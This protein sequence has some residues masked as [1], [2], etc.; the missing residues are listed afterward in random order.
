MGWRLEGD[1][2]A[3]KGEGNPEDKWEMLLPRRDGLWV[4]FAGVSGGTWPC[5]Q[6][7]NK[8]V[9]GERLHSQELQEEPHRPQREKACPGRCASLRCSGVLGKKSGARDLWTNVPSLAPSKK[10]GWRVEC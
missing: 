10:S 5:W 2:H 6:P 1:R 3:A 8:D 7:Q 4:T 9:A